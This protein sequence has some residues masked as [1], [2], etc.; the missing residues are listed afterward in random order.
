MKREIPTMFA[1][2]GRKPVSPPARSPIET[3][4]PAR[5]LVDRFARRIWPTVVA[6][7]AAFL[8]L[9]IVFGAVPPG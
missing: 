4:T 9:L 2:A 3:P 1:G 7:A 6:V 5:V 8:I